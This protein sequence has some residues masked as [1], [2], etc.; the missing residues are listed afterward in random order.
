MEKKPNIILFITHDQGQHLSCYQTPTNRNSVK[1]PNLDNLAESGVK[2]VN[3]FC[4]APQCSPSRGSIQTSLYPHQNGLMGLVNWGWALSET[5]KTLPMYLK[6]NGYTTHLIGLQHESPDAST[7]GYDTFSQKLIDHFTPCTMM[8][9]RYQNFLQKHQKDEK[10]FYLCIGTSEVHRPFNVYGTPVSPNSVKIPPYLPD[11]RKVRVD[12][13]EYYGAIHS[14]DWTIG[15]ILEYLDQLGLKENTLFIFTTDHGIPFPRAK[16]SLYDPGIKTAL[17]MNLPNS[18]LL[19]NGQTVDSFISNIDLLPTIL[20][21]IG[22]EIPIDIE[23]ISFLSILRNEKES[24]RDEIFAEKSYHELY[25]P[26]RCIRTKDYKFISNLNDS[27]KL[28]QLTKDVLFWKLL[29]KDNEQLRTKEELYNLRNDPLEKK[30]LINN[31]DYQ[32][33]IEDLRKKLNNWMVHTKDPFLTGVI[34]PTEGWVRNQEHFKVVNDLVYYTL[35]NKI[36]PI[37]L[38]VPFI[39]KLFN[40]VAKQLAKKIQN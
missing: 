13:A 2:F 8:I 21:L 36:L 33:V 32:P 25:D 26:M 37:L 10:P 23:G 6:E 20:D 11:H 5:C 12:L 34:H 17:I 4:T 22:A 1:T 3:H 15:K 39:K 40:G 18:N 16:C 31:R 29:K 24:I 27:D 7:L 38:R 28:Y 14:V 30:N 35:L 9:R 19:N